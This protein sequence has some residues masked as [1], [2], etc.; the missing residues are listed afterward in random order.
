MRARDARHSFGNTNDPGMLSPQQM[1]LG[2]FEMLRTL[3]D[4]YGQCDCVGL[5]PGT[6]ERRSETGL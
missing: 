1:P 5:V 4:F 6:I 2:K 3:T